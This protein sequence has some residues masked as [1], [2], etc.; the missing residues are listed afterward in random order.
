[1]LRIN[2]TFLPLAAIASLTLVGDIS[3]AQ[4]GRA[5]V[6]LAGTGTD[7]VRARTEQHRRTNPFVRGPDYLPW[8]ATP[9]PGRCTLLRSGGPQHGRRCR[10]GGP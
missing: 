10:S 3:V 6:E 8:I 7:L 5:R 2:Q 1:M 9:R 4:D